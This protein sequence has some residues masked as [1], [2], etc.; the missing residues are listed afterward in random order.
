MR[1]PDRTGR[2]AGQR[3]A[4]RQCSRALGRHQPAARLV[5]ADG[6]AR[7]H[8]RE[9][10]LEIRDIGSQHRLEVGIQHRGGEPLVL[11]EL[12]LD[13]ERGADRHVRQG[14]S[15]RGRDA[16]LVLG[17]AE[18]EEQ[19]HGA[20]VGA[21][22]AHLLHRPGDGVGGGFGDRVA[23]RVHPLVDLEPVATL[24]EGRR[25][26]L[27]ERVHVR[28]DLA[29]DLEQVAEPSRGDHR[30]VAAAALDER[31]GAHRGAMGESP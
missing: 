10:V 25:M 11:A 5:D 17:V 20:G 13:L 18:R 26:V 4:H 27:G 9:L 28:A 29:A 24:D 15:N 23:C 6:G 14:G 16:V 19:A 2:G 8:A 31:V 30:D 21:A 1:R 12:G 7:R 22:R 3:G